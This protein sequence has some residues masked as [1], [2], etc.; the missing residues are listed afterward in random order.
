MTAI[1]DRRTL[2][3][4]AAIAG[5][6]A[7]IPRVAHAG[8]APGLD[9]VARTR[10][11]RFGSAFAWSRPGADAGS[12]TNAR[13]S[14][15]LTRDCG[16]VVPENEMKWQF[17]RPSAAA[18]RLD[19]LDAMIAFADAEAM[20]VRGHTLLWHYDRWFPQ[21]LN[22]HD[23]GARPAAEA[24]WL[25]TTHIA[26]LAQRYGPVICSYDVVNE[27]VDPE[28]G[29][30]RE[31]VLSN[32]MGGAQPVL[33]LAFHAAR[34]AA[35]HAELVYNDF[36]SWEAGHEPHRAGVLQLLEGFRRRGT[37][38]DA[39]GIQSHIKIADR[40]SSIAGLVARNTPGWRAFLDEVT[41]M[42]FRLVI[43]E[44]DVRDHG[45]PSGVAPR[46]RG[47]AEYAGAYL[48]MMLSYPEVNDVVV[49]GMSDKYS[50]LRGFDPRSDGEMTRGCPFDAKL[51]PKP[52]RDAIARALL[53]A[54]MRA[55][56]PKRGM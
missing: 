33:D 19:R 49:W 43:T 35:P 20:A 42:G 45:L 53:A 1:L 21:W 31:T 15:L 7:L 55:P 26:T 8:S 54:P 27:A 30:L 14:R 18:F 5:S 6:A 29:T 39:L 3:R 52:L 23:F 36:M 12:F 28:T 47:V 2:L 56:A 37:P 13:Y 44:F 4:S 41:A 46:D 11:L 38:V 51:R 24:E 17:T 32:A 40:T 50:W 34:E 22:D 10:N 25:L 9:A 16:L 48:D